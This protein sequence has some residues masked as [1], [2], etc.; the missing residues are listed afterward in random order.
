MY[1]QLVAFV[2]ALVSTAA[3][4]TTNFWN[5]WVVSGPESSSLAGPIWAWKGIWADCI[6]YYGG[7]YY[8]EEQKSLFL[9][10]GMK[11]FKRTL[12]LAPVLDLGNDGL[13]PATL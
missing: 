5:Q 10:L 2:F 1:G 4:V 8:C 13:N 11:K 7:Q 3:V 9:E 12:N 6:Q